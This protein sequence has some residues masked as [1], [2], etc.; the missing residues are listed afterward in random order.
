MDLIAVVTASTLQPTPGVFLYE[1]RVAGALHRSLEYCPIHHLF[2]IID[3]D[4]ALQ[5][6]A[7]RATIQQVLQW[8][9]RTI[10]NFIQ[11]GYR[12]V[13]NH[14]TA[15]RTRAI[16]KTRDIRTYFRKLIQR[17]DQRPP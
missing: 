11:T 3:N 14:T 4:Q 5:E 1:I 17:D 7:P 8:P 13:R 2:S 6:Y 9:V 10:R 15:A 16:Y 12:H